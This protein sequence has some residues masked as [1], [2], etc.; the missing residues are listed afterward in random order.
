ME[1]ETKVEIVGDDLTFTNVERVEMAVQK[2]ACDGLL[3]KI[4]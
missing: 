2:K 3:L 4:D 1:K